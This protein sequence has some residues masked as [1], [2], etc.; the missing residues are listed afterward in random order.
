MFPSRGFAAGG[1]DGDARQRVDR[2]QGVGAGGFDGPR[3]RA[4]VGDVRR[5][6]D[7]ERQVGRSAD[8]GRDGRRGVGV[9]RELETAFADVRAADVELD[10]GHAR[11]AVEPPDDLDVVVDRFARDV[12]DD[13][14]PPAGPR[15][16]VLLDDRVHA[17]VLEADRVQHAGRGLG[18]ARGH[19]PDARSERGALAADRPEPI[20]LDDVAVLDPV[21]ERAGRDEDRVLEDETAPKIDR[22]IDIDGVG[23]GHETHALDR[24]WS[25][26]RTNERRRICRGRRLVRQADRMAN[27][28]ALDRCLVRQADRWANE[29]DAGRPLVRQADQDRG[30]A[31]RFTSRPP[32]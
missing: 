29:A 19:V 30:G 32:S 1:R 9:D 17:R 28:N 3:D 24:A 26:R 13:R 2:G 23:R 10:P 18:D 12:D 6:L 31:R 21:A 5:E 8:S 4:D 14:R 15:A 25:G 27:R 11:H 22:E 20:D 7:E 16:G